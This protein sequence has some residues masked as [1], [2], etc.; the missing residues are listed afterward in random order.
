MQL[1]NIEFE[2]VRAGAQLNISGD[3]V[4]LE[5][6]VKCGVG[7][8]DVALLCGLVSSAEQENQTG[9]VMDEVDPVSRSER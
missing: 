2:M 1:E 9:P 5:L 7:P 3:G 6:Q 8:V 4:E